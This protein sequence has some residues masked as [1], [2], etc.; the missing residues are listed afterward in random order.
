M[1]WLRIAMTLAIVS[2]VCR[3]ARTAD[4]ARNLLKNAGF[5]E[6]LEAAWEKGVTAIPPSGSGLVQDRLLPLNS[7][8]DE[9]IPLAV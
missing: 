9:V 1:D 7:V 6:S 2:S 8:F 5:E 3:P 4:P